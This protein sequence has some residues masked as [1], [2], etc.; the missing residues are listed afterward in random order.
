MFIWKYLDIPQE[1][2]EAVQAEFKNNLPDNMEFFQGIKINKKTFFGLELQQT[3]LIQVGPMSGLNDEGIHI[4]VHHLAYTADRLAINIP[5]ENCEG[6]ITKF[7]KNKNPVVIKK[8]PNGYPYADLK[9]EECDQID[10]FKL[11]RPVLFNASIPHSVTNPQTVCRRA[12][13]L[14]FAVEPWHLVN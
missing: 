13:S 1:E 2:I 3:V 12:I 7:W 8:T 6:S 10:E 9:K 5:F 11:S 4:D 14:R